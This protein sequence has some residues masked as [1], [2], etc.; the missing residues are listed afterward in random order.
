[1]NRIMID[2]HP[3]SRPDDLIML[4][5]IGLNNIFNL[6]GIDDLNQW[7]MELEEEKFKEVIT[8][9]P[10]LVGE[11]FARDSDLDGIPELGAAIKMLE[12]AG[13]YTRRGSILAIQR[14]A[15]DRRMA[16]LDDDIEETEEA[17]E[18]YM[19]LT[20]PL[21]ES[22]EIE[23][24]SLVS[25]ESIIYDFYENFD[26]ISQCKECGRVLTINDPS[27]LVNHT[28]IL[29]PSQYLD[30]IKRNRDSGSGSGTE[31]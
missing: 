17:A 22:S 3:T 4:K 31:L 21:S 10:E 25:N 16:S 6:G 9:F 18:K 27:S 23:T 14:D 5:Q 28:K 7:K 30:Y 8:R 20:M 2:P 12:L 15:N 24:A 19:K 11:L 26:N 1:M 13:F 29:H